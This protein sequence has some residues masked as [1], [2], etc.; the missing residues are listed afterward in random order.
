[1]IAAEKSLATRRP[2]IP[3][4]R[5][6]LRTCSRPAS[7]GWKSAGTTLPPEMP[8]STT[9]VKRTL[10]VNKELTR[11]R[12]TPS[13]KKTSSVASRK[14]SKNS[15]VNM[16]PSRARRATRTLLA[17]PNSLR[18]SMKVCIYSCCNGRCLEKPASTCRLVSPKQAH[19]NGHHYED[20]NNQGASTKDEIFNTVQECRDHG[21]ASF[22]LAGRARRLTP[23]SPTRMRALSAV[24]MILA[25]PARSA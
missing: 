8:S 23:C 14:A 6:F 4:L 16:L 10:G 21:P 24:S 25:I 15:A 2:T 19:D 7:V 3:D 12:S 5:M 22:E 18:Y 11:L 13:I 17:P 1:M 20:P 9:S